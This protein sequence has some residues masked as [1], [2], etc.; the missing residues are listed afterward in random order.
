MSVIVLQLSSTSNS[1]IAQPVFQISPLFPQALSHHPLQKILTFLAILLGRRLHKHR[2]HMG[3][4]YRIHSRTVT[5][6]PTSTS[7]PLDHDALPCPPSQTSQAPTNQVLTATLLRWNWTWEAQARGTIY[8]EMRNP[9]SFVSFMLPPC[10]R[11]TYT[12]CKA[13]Q[14][15]RVRF[16]NTNQNWYHKT[17]DDR[18]ESGWSLLIWTTV[19]KYTQRGSVGIQL[20]SIH[21]KSRHGS[22]SSL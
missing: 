14:A 5:E 6:Q 16:I 15:R 4:T 12:I 2:T 17:I 19:R 1:R 10:I 18:S 11:P 9:F 20:N 22:R 7:Y 21:G 13:K 8:G 3:R